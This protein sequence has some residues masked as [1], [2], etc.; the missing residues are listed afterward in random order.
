[1]QHH[2][3]ELFLFIYCTFP[4]IVVYTKLFLNTV[5]LIFKSNKKETSLQKTCPIAA[6]LKHDYSS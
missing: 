4:I 6:F 1:M 5:Y 3:L 2:D